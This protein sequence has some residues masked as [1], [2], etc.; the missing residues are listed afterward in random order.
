MP[1][2]IELLKKTRLF[3]QMVKADQIAV[4]VLE[5]FKHTDLEPYFLS[6]EMTLIV[7]NFV[8]NSYRNVHLFDAKEIV[9]RVLTKVYARELTADQKNKVRRD[10]DYLV[11]KRMYT[12]IS[13]AYYC[14]YNIY[15]FFFKSVN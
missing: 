12:L 1:K 7:Y 13:D 2:K 14:A 6:A 11:E 4:L 15:F 5:L 10:I 9:L 3:K 8:I